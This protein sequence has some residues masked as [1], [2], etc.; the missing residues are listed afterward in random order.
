MAEKSSSQ[1]EPIGFQNRITLPA[2]AKVG[3]RTPPADVVDPNK[4]K[5]S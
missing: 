1:I 5:A 2:L 3:V 4:S